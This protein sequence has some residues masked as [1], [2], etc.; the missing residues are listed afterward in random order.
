MEGTATLDRVIKHKYPI[1]DARPGRH[2]QNCRVTT[3]I[4][5]H[6]QAV[7]VQ[8]LVDR[9]GQLLVFPQTT[10]RLAGKFPQILLDRKPDRPLQAIDLLLQL[11]KALLGVNCIDGR[12]SVVH[13]VVQQSNGNGN[14][15]LQSLYKLYKVSRAGNGRPTDFSKDGLFSPI[16]TANATE[17]RF[18]SSD[19][20]QRGNEPWISVVSTDFE[21]TFLI[22]NP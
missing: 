8:Q 16:R 21:L 7:A 15:L 19:R 12:I 6:T 1:G 17:R 3:L 9:F 4:A 13:E 11:T 10:E 20:S 18:L 2:T 22:S 5:P 14:V